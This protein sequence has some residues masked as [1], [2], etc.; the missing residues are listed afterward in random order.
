MTSPTTDRSRRQLP[1]RRQCSVH[2]FELDGH[3]CVVTLGYYADGTPGEVFLTS[4]K[5]GSTID[6]VLS[7][8]AI[9]ASLALQHGVPPETL[10]KSMGRRTRRRRASVVGAAMDILA[11][12]AS[13]SPFEVSR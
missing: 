13:V 4:G 5:S 9:L 11:C 7:D 1:S 6:A 10:A 2:E 12:A 8:A 3:S